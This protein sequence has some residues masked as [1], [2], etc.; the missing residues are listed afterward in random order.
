MESIN[1]QCKS[2]IRP[3]WG[4][5]F[6]WFT[7]RTD[8][9][10]IDAYKAYVKATYVEDTDLETQIKHH[11][12]EINRLITD[13]IRDN[14]DM[15]K[16]SYCCVYSFPDNMTDYIDV[17]LRPFAEKGYQ[18]IK[19]SDRISELKGVNACVISWYREKL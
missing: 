14:H 13:R 17:I 8:V 11:Q 2:N 15:R 3:F 19:L 12:L 16:F 5:L 6:K 4:R 7:D 18:I 10:I 9:N 1:E